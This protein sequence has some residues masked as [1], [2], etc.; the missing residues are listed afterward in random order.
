MKNVYQDNFDSA[1]RGRH[2]GQRL[3]PAVEDIEVLAVG[4]DTTALLACHLT[5]DP[6]VDQVFKRLSD[7]GK[8][9]FELLRRR[10]DCDE[11]AALHQ[12]VNPECRSRTAPERLDCTAVCLEKRHDFTGGI[13]GLRR[14]IPHAR[15]EVFHPG[16]PSAVLTDLLQQTIVVSASCFEVEAEIQEGLTQ[17]ASITQHERDQQAP[18][19][20][21]AVEE[22]M[23]RLELHMRE[24]CLDQWW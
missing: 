6:E 7:R 9:K 16:F 1:S 23:D 14:R 8:R 11:R 10:L 3:S 4:K 5:H 20:S 13:D 2:G 15:Q 21:V 18:E 24:P 19:T 22:R 12:F 17:C